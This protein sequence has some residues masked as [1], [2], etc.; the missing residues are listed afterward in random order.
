MEPTSGGTISTAPTV[1]PN[2]VPHF[3]SS[4]FDG[5]QAFNFSD[6]DDYLSEDMSEA[7]FMWEELPAGS[8]SQELS[9][10]LESDSS[11]EAAKLQRRLQAMG[12]IAERELMTIRRRQLSP[13]TCYG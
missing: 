8:A 10:A 4:A 2:D 9:A 12:D 3:S 1:E 13:I 5:M 6:V 11:Q 7:A